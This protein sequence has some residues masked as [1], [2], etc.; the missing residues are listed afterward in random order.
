MSVWAYVPY[1][2]AVYDMCVFGRCRYALFFGP[3]LV[4]AFA[5]AY[6]QRH[7]STNTARQYDTTSLIVHSV[8][9]RPE[10]V[11]LIWLAAT[12]V[13]LA[14]QCRSR[15]DSSAEQNRNH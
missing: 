15:V 13:A 11:R 7:A 6:Y 3:L 12:A 4:R 2:C 9:Q 5:Q 10:T 8:D 1:V 14:D